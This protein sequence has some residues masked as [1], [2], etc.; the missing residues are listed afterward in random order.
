VGDRFLHLA[1]QGTIHPCVP[2]SCA[3]G[4]DILYLHIVSCHYSTAT[5]YELV[6]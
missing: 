3:T 1:C 5:R 2:V 4:Y 6:A